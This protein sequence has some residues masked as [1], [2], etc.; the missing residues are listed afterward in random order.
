[1]DLRNRKILVTGGAGFIGSHVVDAL[2][3]EGADVFIIDN[4][5]TG[6]KENLNPNAIFYEMNIA[7][8]NVRD[9]FEKEKPEIIYHFAFN[10]L[11]PK[12]VEN[13]LIDMDSISGSINILIN[14][15]KYGVKKVIFSSSGF[16]YGNTH[17]LP[18][19]ET[20]PVDPISPYVVA[21]L[22]VENYLKFFKKSYGLSYVVFRNAA[23]YGPGQIT[24]AM[25]D[26][27]R[28][29]KSGKQAD[30]W[31]DGNKTR[32][33]VFIDDVVS[34]N[35]LALDLRDDFSNPIFNVGNGKETTL[36][37]LYFKIAKILGKE[38]KPIYHKDRPGEQVRYCLD[39]SK[40]K[41][42]MK[43]KP[44]YDLD[45]GLEMVLKYWS[46]NH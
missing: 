8:P 37:D 46:E 40:L 33:Y 27:V 42:Y 23:V 41:K 30:I 28:K 6:R 22:A 21:K 24:G 39:N 36:N 15:Q 4:L 10:V 1:M 35:L 5:S 32:D 34:A 14:C 38:P 45:K 26:Y 9:V 17:N 2:I 25:A 7:D 19:K 31:G 18:A 43:W 29:L 16:V 11:V 13:P 20:E 3:K 12:S 44:K